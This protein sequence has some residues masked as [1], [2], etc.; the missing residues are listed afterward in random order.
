MKNQQMEVRLGEYGSIMI[1]HKTRMGKVADVM[2]IGNLIRE[3]KGLRVIELREVLSKQD[4]WEFIDALQRHNSN[5]PDSG[6]LKT[7]TESTNYNHPNSGIIPEL[8]TVLNF[9]NKETKGTDGKVKYA[10]LITQFPELIQSKRG[11]YG[12]TWAELHILLKI[13][14]YL[15]KDLEVII[16]KTFVDGK[17]LELRDEGGEQFKELNTLIDTLPDRSLALKPKGNKGVYVQISKAVREKL[18]V[19]DTKGYNEEEHDARVQKLR[20]KIIDKSS[21]DAV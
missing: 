1:G 13:A 15:D 10:P 2:A 11:K 20:T 9:E 3:H 7:L 21:A 17:L 12:G 16:Y 6:E 18:E 5:Y 4:L 14:A 8:K 19:L